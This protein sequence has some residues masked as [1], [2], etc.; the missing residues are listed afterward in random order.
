MS[1]LNINKSSESSLNK[2]ID[3]LKNINLNI[4]KKKYN[5][6]SEENKGINDE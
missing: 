1:N 3:S 6:L 5:N 2:K 4:I